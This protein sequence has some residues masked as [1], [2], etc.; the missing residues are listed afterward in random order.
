MDQNVNKDPLAPTKAEAIGFNDRR[1]DVSKSAPEEG[2][3]VVKGHS[4]VSNDPSQG[5]ANARVQVPINGARYR[6]HPQTTAP[7]TP[8]SAATQANG[9]IVGGAPATDYT[10]SGDYGGGEVGEFTDATVA[11]G[12]GPGEHLIRGWTQRG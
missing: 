3:S 1:Y 12:R 9:R 10:G 5:T 8:Y 4:K 7:N 11:A 6:V 2:T